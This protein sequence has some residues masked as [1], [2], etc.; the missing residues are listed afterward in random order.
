MIVIASV[1]GNTSKWADLLGSIL[2]SAVNIRFVDACRVKMNSSE[3]AQA[4]AMIQSSSLILFLTST[5]GNGELPIESHQFFSHLFG[6]NKRNIWAHKQCAVL[7]FGSSAYPIFC[8][9][10][11]HLSDTLAYHG[12]DEIV[13]LGKCD[14]VKGETSTFYNWVSCKLRDVAKK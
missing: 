1:T 11:I 6:D 13:T 4:L 12:A 9:A 10:A 7:G 5:Q 3:A 8:G 14:A 2:R